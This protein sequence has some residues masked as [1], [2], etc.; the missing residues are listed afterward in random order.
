[1]YEQAIARSERLRQ[2]GLDADRVMLSMPRYTTRQRAQILYNHVYFSDLP[3]TH[4]AALLEDDFYREIVQHQRFNPRIIEWMASHQRIR[5]VP[6]AKYKMFIRRLLDNPLEIWRHAYEEELSDSARSLLLT[7]WSFEGKT[8]MP[9][10]R[11]AFLKLHAHRAQKY[12]LT[13]TP[14]DFNRA[15]RELGGSFARPGENSGL[16]IADPSVLDLISEVLREAPENVVDLLVGAA[17]FNQIERLWMFARQGNAAAPRK[18]WQDASSEAAPVVKTLMLK[19]RRVDHPDGIISWHGPTYERRLAVVLEVA[20][21]IGTNEY[22]SLV[23]P[24]VARL[25]EEPLDDGVDINTLVDLVVSLEGKGM[26]EFT[27]FIQ[28]LSERVFDAVRQGCRSDEL[29]EA[30][31]L[32]DDPPADNDFDAL[33]AGYAM[34]I[35]HYFSSERLECRSDE[36][37]DGLIEDLTLFEKTLDVETEGSVAEVEEARQEFQ[38][39]EERYHDAYANDYKDRWREAQHQDESIADMFGSLKFD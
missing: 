15:L 5:N 29:R 13:C 17:L 23:D 18:S 28:P 26:A 4:I 27:A 37:F 14:Q 21:R 10:L 20:A 31:R 11:K 3:D 36:E 32:L 6:V 2:A 16:E 33:R 19:N 9:L 22:C 25:F 35:E 30:I 24:I 7:L 8:G 34:Y 12:R 1:M 39:S 38:E